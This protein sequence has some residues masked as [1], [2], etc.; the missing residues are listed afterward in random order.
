MRLGFSDAVLA[1]R[2]LFQFAGYDSSLA[3]GQ[4]GF[5]DF[6]DAAVNVPAGSK[7]EEVMDSRKY[8][9]AI[10][11][12]SAKPTAALVLNLKHNKERKMDI[13]GRKVD[14]GASFPPLLPQEIPS[15]FLQ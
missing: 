9:C 14:F 10:A 12:P 2:E 8:S 13:P 11:K 15:R 5:K 1:E 3:S 6:V 7:L 4:A